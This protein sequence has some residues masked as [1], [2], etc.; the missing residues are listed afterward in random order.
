MAVEG[1]R[2]K[3][4]EV[5]YAGRLELIRGRA[6]SCLTPYKFDN[7]QILMGGWSTAQNRAGAY[8]FHIY[9]WRALY[10]FPN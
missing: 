4:A 1:R 3:L 6:P 9:R 2:L 8:G 7:R 10:D 5:G